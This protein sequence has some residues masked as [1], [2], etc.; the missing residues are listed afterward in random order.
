MESVLYRVEEGRAGK[1]RQTRILTD[2]GHP[3]L[4]LRR[5]RRAGHMV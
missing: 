2:A 3:Y 4:G 1:R 5:G